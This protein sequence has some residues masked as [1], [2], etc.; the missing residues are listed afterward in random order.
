MFEANKEEFPG[1]KTFGTAPDNSLVI[2]YD[3]KNTQQAKRTVEYLPKILCAFFTKETLKILIPD[4]SC[5]VSESRVDPASDV[6]QEPQA[7][8]TPLKALATGLSISVTSITVVSEPITLKSTVQTYLVEW[9]Q[10]QGSY[11]VAMAIGA[12]VKD[13]LYITSRPESYNKYVGLV[14]HL[15]HRMKSELDEES[16]KSVVPFVFQ[17]RVSSMTGSQVYK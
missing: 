6:S 3:L 8:K 5:T 7:I 11:D 1:I 13:Q 16:Y 10:G 4:K 14:G 2:G 9:A 17:K 12:D 15:V